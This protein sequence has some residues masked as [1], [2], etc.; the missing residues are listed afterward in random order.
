VSVSINTT[1]VP[2][3]NLVILTLFPSLGTRTVGGSF[4]VSIGFDQQDRRVA[5]TSSSSV[6][7]IILF[8]KRK[9]SS[10]C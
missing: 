7:L 1:T 10:C 5:V 6:T 8:D 4:G 3:K 9:I 2:V